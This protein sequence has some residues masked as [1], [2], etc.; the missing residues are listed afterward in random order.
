MT[1]DAKD[2]ASAPIPAP[3]PN[4]SRL[5]APAQADTGQQNPPEKELWTGRASWKH[6]AGPLVG[7]WAFAI[8]ALVAGLTL[9]GSVAALQ[10][11][12][13]GWLLATI[14]VLPALYVHANV[15]FRHYSQTYRLTTQRL[16]FER[17]ILGKVTDQTE[18]IRVDDVRVTQSPIDR[19][20]N[21]GTVEV[22]A[23]SDETDGSVR[24]VGVKN[25]HQLADQIR[26][27]T[28]QLRQKSLFI[29]QM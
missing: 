8:V 7:V 20:W 26:Q 9:R 22:I 21:L 6:F 29:E 25:P 15:A 4:D 28:R 11:P 2:D 10:S 27:H 17:G 24:L 18:L 19:I 3:A 16:F 23:K 1:P 13:F 14:V 5:A 12:W